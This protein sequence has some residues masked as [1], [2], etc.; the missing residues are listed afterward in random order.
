M[1][2]LFKRTEYVEEHDVSLVCSYRLNFDAARNCGNIIVYNGM[3]IT[4]ESFELYME[5]LE[6]GLNQ[7]QVKERIEK[8]KVEISTGKLDVSF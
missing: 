4:E 7:D 1:D 8:L 6:C 2:E 5:Y 3:D